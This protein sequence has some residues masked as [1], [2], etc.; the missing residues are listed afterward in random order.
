M[1]CKSGSLNI[2][3]HE[4]GGK[5]RLEFI[6]KTPEIFHRSFF[7]INTEYYTESHIII[8]NL[9]IFSLISNSHYIYLLTVSTVHIRQIV[10]Q[11]L[12]GSSLL[13]RDFMIFVDRIHIHP[14][15]SFNCQDPLLQSSTTTLH[16]VCK[17]TF[18]I[19]GVEELNPT[20]YI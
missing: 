7:A 12:Q 4:G 17:G 9:P 14:P 1:I 15:S 2:I 11:E 8:I 19:C 10:V 6:S 5:L 16:A 3:D 20:L 13:L 18:L